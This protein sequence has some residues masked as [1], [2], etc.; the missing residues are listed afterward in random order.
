MKV[1]AVPYIPGLSNADLLQFA[2]QSKPVQR[3]VPELTDW[4]H[5]ERKWLCDVLYTLD[6]ECF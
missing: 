2:I 5:L 3:Y 6:T 1:S 4:V